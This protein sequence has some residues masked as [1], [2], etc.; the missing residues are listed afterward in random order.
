LE[1]LRIAPDKWLEG[2]GERLATELLFRGD[3]DAACAAGA[4]TAMMGVKQVSASASASCLFISSIVRRQWTDD[5]A[6]Q[7]VVI[8]ESI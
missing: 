7:H 5:T 3:A 6:K 4:A 2:C 1:K 8:S